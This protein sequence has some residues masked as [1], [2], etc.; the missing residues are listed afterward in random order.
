MNRLYLLGAAA[1]AFALG[2]T[3]AQASPRMLDM[4]GS[5]TLTS[6]SQAS[7]LSSA[8]KKSRKVRGGV[9]GGRDAKGTGGGRGGESGSR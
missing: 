1:A 7:D 5:K 9:R 8:R 3:A 6:V 4:T 2:L